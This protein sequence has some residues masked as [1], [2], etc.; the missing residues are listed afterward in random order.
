MNETQYVSEIN[1][2]KIK[3]SEAR[4]DIGDLTNLNTTEKSNV[5][6]AINEV[7]TNLG[8]L[9]NLNTTEK[10]S[11]VGAINEVN[12]NIGGLTNLNTTEKSSVVGAINEVN[13]KANDISKLNFTDFITYNTT[14]D[15]IYSTQNCT[16]GNGN[17]TVACDSTGSTG[18]IYSDIDITPTDYTSDCFIT[19]KT[20]LRPTENFYISPAGFSRNRTTNAIN[21]CYLSLYTDGTVTIQIV[22][23]D[24]NTIHNIIL[25]PC[26]Y[27]MKNFGDV[28]I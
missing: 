2:Y 11:A 15:N 21:N 5:V 13:I 4:N 18:K 17:I 9:T 27:F 10:S 7:N 6:G 22:P 12:S 24:S 1:G 14:N 25:W 19:I 3:D 16:I 8:D 26:V 28:S 20:N 23:S